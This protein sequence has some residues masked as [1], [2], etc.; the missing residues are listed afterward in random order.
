MISPTTARSQLTD[1]LRTVVFT[2]APYILAENVNGYGNAESVD[3]LLAIDFDGDNY[4]GNNAAHVQQGVVTD[5]RPRVYFSIVET[6]GADYGQFFIGYYF[7]HPRDGG[8]DFQWCDVIG[9]YW[10]SGGGHQNDLEGVML[11]VQ[12]DPY[13]PYGRLNYA[14]TQAHG[15]MLPAYDSSFGYSYH[16]V[17]A[18][19]GG[20]EGTINHSHDPNVGPRAIV[21]IAESTHGTYVFPDYYHRTWDTEVSYEAGGVGPYG[22]YSYADWGGVASVI[23]SGRSLVG[24]FP[25]ASEA[26]ISPRL[27]PSVYYGVYYYGLTDITTTPFWLL[28]SSPGQFYQGTPLDLG[29]GLSGLSD[30]ATSSGGGDTANPPWQWHG[31]SGEGQFGFYWYS[32]QSDNTGGGAGRHDWPQVPYGRFVT[33]PRSAVNL[34]FPWSVSASTYYSYNPYIGS[35]PPPPPPT[36]ITAISVSGPTRVNGCTG[37]TWTANVSGGVTPIVYQWTVENW[38]EN[39]GTDNHLYYTNTG[40]APSIFVRVTATDANGSTKTSSS[41]KTN[42][43]LPGAC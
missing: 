16:S 6:G 17:Q 14:L 4:A 25:V 30:F 31:G 33:D 35:E 22:I 12:K 3:H 15:A 19:T 21:I 36:G 23:K 39:T 24:Y 27:G 41:Y 8:H 13:S 1:R 11:V 42:V 18:P 10:S 32:Y 37:G 43:Y 38:S 20:W 2:H 28:R 29:H 5:G 26:S 34:Y 40:T 9:C 7:Y